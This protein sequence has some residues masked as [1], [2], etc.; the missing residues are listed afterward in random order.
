MTYWCQIF[1]WA[2]YVLDLLPITFILHS[3][4]WV[5][6]GSLW[7]CSS[8]L[9]RKSWQAFIMFPET[10]LFYTTHR[11]AC[12]RSLHLGDLKSQIITD[13]LSGLQRMAVTRSQL[14]VMALWCHCIPEI[15][16]VYMWDSCTQQLSL[17]SA[18]QAF[19]TWRLCPQGQTQQRHG[20]P[21]RHFDGVYRK[22]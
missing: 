6:S 15:L 11:V 4:R 18:V 17:Q 21:P 7:L 20:S 9:F 2:V 19:I 8:A 22:R 13:Q 10:G 1:P 14:C 12:N 5:C 16:T 3:P